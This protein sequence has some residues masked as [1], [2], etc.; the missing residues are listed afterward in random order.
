MPRPIKI[1][2]C[3]LTSPPTVKEGFL[4]LE[5]TIK[6]ITAQG[7]ADLAIFPE[8]FVQGIVADAEHKIFDEG[9]WEEHVSGIAKEHGLDICVGT[10][11]ER[12][13][14]KDG[15][16]DG[17]G[18]GGVKEKKYNTAYYFN[19]TGEVVGKYRK[20]NLWHPLVA[21]HSPH[22]HTHTSSH[23]N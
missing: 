20:R 8:Y 10:F 7:G 6:E 16:E 2:L 3:Q 22:L 12:V 4:K 21:S 1:A 14:E 19:K 15:G 11:V 17:G 23:P 5:S 18:G 9:E 13:R